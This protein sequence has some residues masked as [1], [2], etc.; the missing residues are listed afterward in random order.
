MILTLA[1]KEYREHR[2]IWLTMVVVTGLMA[3]VLAPLIAPR[4]ASMTQAGVMGI[5]VLG[6]AAA[7]GVVCGAMMLAGEAENGTQ[8]FL[9]IFLGRRGLLWWWKFLFGALL[10]ASEG[11]A[12]GV[13]L[14]FMKQAPPNWLPIFLGHGGE[15][16]R[17]P[18]GNRV[19]VGPAFWIVVLPL[20]TLEAYAWGMLG[21]SL[22]RLVLSGAAIAAMIAAPFLLV[23]LLTPPPASLFLRVIG[24]GAAVAVSCAAFMAQSRDVA[25]GPPPKREDLPEP[26]WV[27][28]VWD[29][30]DEYESEPLL[31]PR[32]DGHARPQAAQVVLLE[33]AT[34][35]ADYPAF[36]RTADI[37]REETAQ[38]AKSPW[39]VLWWLAVQQA[40]VLFLIMAGVSLFLG[41]FMP[42]HGQVLWPLTT[43]AIGIACGTATFASEQS[44][45][46]HQFLSSQH[47][48]LSMFWI[49]KVL[50]WFG[51]AIAA[52][53]IAAGGLLLTSLARSLP[54]FA[55]RGGPAPIGA[56]FGTLREELGPLLFYGVWLVYGFCVGQVFV[57]LCRKNI[58]AVLISAIVSLAAVGIWM[59]SLLCRGMNGWQVWLPPIFMLSGTWL[60]IR[61]WA[62]GR[63]KERSPIA[64]LVGVGVVGLAWLG[65]HLAYRAWSIPD[66][67]EPLDRAGFRASTMSM[68]MANEKRGGQKT[69]EATLEFDKG[70][71]L[72]TLT[73]AARLPVGIIETPPGDGPSPLPR[74]L[75]PAG[76]M[77]DRLARLAEE[78][79]N[80][81]RPDAALDYIRLML[82][83]SRNLR[84]R[85]PESAYFLG[86]MIEDSALHSLNAALARHKPS[87][88]FLKRALAEL[89][90]HDADAPTA[91]DCV[92]T[93]CFRAGGLVNAPVAWTFYA[94]IEGHGRVREGWLAGA[95]ALSLELPW[96]Q[97]RKLRLWRAVW[98]GLLRGA[99]TPLWQLQRDFGNKLDSGKDSTREILRG[100]VPDDNDPSMTRDRLARL[101]DE[102]WLSD[103][104][105]F[106]PVMN[107]RV[108]GTRSRCRIDMSRL[109]LALNLYRLHEGRTAP[110][111]ADLV[112]RYLPELPID[113]YRGEAYAYRVSQGERLEI[114]MFFDGEAGEPVNA[115]QGILWSIGP[116]RTDHGGRKDGARLPDDD[117][118]WFASGFDLITVVPHWP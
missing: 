63:I 2:S 113:P 61:A 34:A 85:A 75:D 71:W 26:K 97:E 83:L 106:A 19:V 55:P 52:A 16:L 80:D 37:P 49:V 68:L 117:T 87:I 10:A 86:T 95:I 84:N 23:A 1:W 108:A 18:M 103:P 58:L 48:P 5:I 4:D 25:L 39:Q 67:V 74:Y 13:V 109:S 33:P 24:V 54:E 28:D 100:W 102:S 31:E 77:G 42:T 114:A 9:D 73:Q 45:R 51:A 110:R 99:E 115:G 92:R 81:N 41:I 76:K 30:L 57:M 66:T 112:P 65:I 21:S 7:Y 79:W 91:L 17:D 59:P 78:A 46:S 32:R 88:A 107:L 62:A 72:A 14:Y 47:F 89:T 118:R 53:L 101:L 116:D 50:F 94:G 44:D 60:L 22:A 6:M 82:A 70:P 111:L 3:Y 38:D 43:L 93:E 36:G 15:A 64:L 96:E 27:E 90:R 69:Q 104:R 20:V 29:E 8:V 35:A 105:L 12:I 56:G 40:W 98:G 11:L